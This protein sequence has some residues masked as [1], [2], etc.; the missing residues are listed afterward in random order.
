MNKADIL[1]KTSIE[2][3]LSEGHTDENPR[4]KWHDGTPAHTLSI[5]G[6][7]H[8]YDISKNEFPITSLRRIVFKKAIG[9]ILWIYRDASND[10]DLLAKKYD[11]HWRDDWDIG[12]RTIG[13]V[14]G[15]TVSNYDMMRK[16]LEGIIKDP[17]GRRHIT[18]FWQYADFEKKHGLKPCCYQTQ[19]LIRGKYID[20][21][22]YQRS[23]DWL[24]AGNLN[25]MQYVALLMMVAKHCGYKPGVFYHMIAN[26]QIY[27]RHMDNALIMLERYEELEK[28]EAKGE[29]LPNPILQFHPAEGTNFWTYQVSDFDIVDYNPIEPQLKFEV[30]V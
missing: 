20:M 18:N 4:P 23:S 10:L 21:I 2:K 7:L 13:E 3:I 15:K 5:N 19:F 30:A 9:E 16:L 17:Y 25:E 1:M 24:T 12:D 26:Q 29:I 14:Y 11:V 8:S 22:L 27:D 6:Q 28:R